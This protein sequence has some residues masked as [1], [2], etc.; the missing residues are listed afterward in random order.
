MSHIKIM[1]GPADGAP[2]KLR[3]KITAELII[4]VESETEEGLRIVRMHKYTLD[5][6]NNV[7]RY[8]GPLSGNGMFE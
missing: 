7:Y 4:R 8:D 6:D 2:V 1:G 5:K 3:H